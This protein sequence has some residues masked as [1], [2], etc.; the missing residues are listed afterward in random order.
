MKTEILEIRNI[1]DSHFYGQATGDMFRTRKELEALG[2][3][4]PGVWSDLDDVLSKHI[5][6]VTQNTDTQGRGPSA[7]TQ[8]PGYQDMPIEI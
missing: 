7:T 3:D 5:D 1:M 2:I 6:R 8:I 4:V